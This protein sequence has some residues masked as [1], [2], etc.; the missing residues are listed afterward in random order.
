ML[1]GWT[2]ET[3]TH[4]FFQAYAKGRKLENTIWILNDHHG[5]AISSFEGMAQLGNKH[6]QNLFKA[7]ERVTIAEIVRMALFFRAL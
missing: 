5:R 7:D 6:F 2:M 3:K 4:K 1:Y